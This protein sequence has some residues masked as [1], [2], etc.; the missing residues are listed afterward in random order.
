MAAHYAIDSS[1]APWG[2]YGDV[3]R[4][5]LVEVLEGEVDQTTIVISR[6]GPFVPPIMF[7][8]GH[9]IVTDDLR[10]KLE[11]ANFTGLKFLP[12]EYGKVVRNDWHTWNTSA[13]DPEFYPDGEPEDYIEAADHDADLVGNMPKLWAWDVA[14]TDDLQIQGTNNFRVDRH[15]GS[16]VA[17]EYYIVW[18][19]DLLKSWLAESA[20]QWIK[21]TPIVPRQQTIRG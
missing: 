9:I 11:R 5:G 18:V 19:S 4:H 15:P 21:F 14:R 12:V 7:P 13:P 2:D 16:D 6:T 10:Q 8:F 17:K 20:G 3:L 1:P